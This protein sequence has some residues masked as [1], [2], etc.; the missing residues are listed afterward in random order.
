MAAP[1]NPGFQ[2]GSGEYPPLSALN[3]LAFCKRRCALHRLESIWVESVHTIH[4]TLLHN[5]VHSK[6]IRVRE[7]KTEIR[8]LRIISHSLKL[9]GVADLVEFKESIG[10]PDPF[11]VEYKRGKIK[12]WENDE[13]Q[14][15][16]QAI[17]LEEMLGKEIKKGA[18]F[19]I[20]SRSRREVILDSE[21]RSKTAGAARD[22]HHL[23]E[24]KQL[25]PPVL[26]PHCRK[27]SLN[28]HCLPRLTSDDASYQKAVLELFK[29]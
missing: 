9:Q 12:S 25:P 6:A 24:Q 8:G 20:T 27:C 3:D 17:C 22:L 11:P 1:N 4:G 13:I 21:L 7:A 15:C 5:R 2:E 29:P 10:E 16:A 26:L 19:H 23:L 18:I 28:R 14:L